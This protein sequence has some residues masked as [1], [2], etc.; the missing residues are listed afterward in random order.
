MTK[1][2]LLNELE[3]TIRHEIKYGIIKNS[4][5]ASST[6]YTFCHIVNRLDLLNAE[7]SYLEFLN[8]AYKRTN[9]ICNECEVKGD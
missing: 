2:E 9:E 3:S 4:S 1:Q 5:D 6:C 7:A 8:A